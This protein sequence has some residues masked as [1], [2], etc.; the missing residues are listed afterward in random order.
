MQPLIL[1]TMIDDCGVDI[2][3]VMESDNLEKIKKVRLLNGYQLQIYTDKL[4]PLHHRPIG[5]MFVK[6]MDWIQQHSMVSPEC[7]SKIPSVY[8]VFLMFQPNAKRAPIFE[9]VN[10]LCFRLSDLDIFPGLIF[11]FVVDLIFVRCSRILQRGLGYRAD[12][13]CQSKIST[14]RGK[15]APLWACGSLRR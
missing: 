9:G 13:Y 14:K 12:A 6:S 10:R 11:C 5:N 2:P 8:Q 3:D 1:L 4:I 7:V 15:Y